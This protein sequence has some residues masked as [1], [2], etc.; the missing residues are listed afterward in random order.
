MSLLNCSKVREIKSVGEEK[1]V[2][3][4]ICEIDKFWAQNERV[5]KWLKINKITGGHMPSRPSA[6]VT[7][8][9]AVFA[10]SPTSEDGLWYVGVTIG[11]RD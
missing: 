7:P 5:K 6:E 9:A 10:R 2:V 8:M 1:S 11:Q 4:R 3:K